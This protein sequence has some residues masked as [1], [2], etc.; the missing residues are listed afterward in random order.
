MSCPTTRAIKGWTEDAHGNRLIRFRRRVE[1]ISRTIVKRPVSITVALVFIFT[2][3]TQTE[4]AEAGP[5][6]DFFRA[7]RSSIA[8]PEQKSR[9]HRSSRKEH[10]ET[11]PSDAANSQT[12]GHQVAGPPDGHNV[13][14]AKATSAPEQEWSNLPYGTPVPGK[15]GL[16]TSPFS[17]EN[18]YIDVH[19]FPPGTPVQDP[20]TGKIFL[21]P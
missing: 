4:V 12:T 5:F 14:V 17:P 8:H 19:G 16:V 9:P 13:R 1:A 7:L 20:Y 18:G 11:P 10:N 2:L 15:Q 6:H 21:T 3:F